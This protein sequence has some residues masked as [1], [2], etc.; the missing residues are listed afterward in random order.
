MT[1][2]TGKFLLWSHTGW[3]FN[4]WKTDEKR[5]TNKIPFVNFYNNEKTTF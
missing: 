3:Q 4:D 5:L 2:A 1:K